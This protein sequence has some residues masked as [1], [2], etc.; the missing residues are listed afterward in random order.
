MKECTHVWK[1]KV[2]RKNNYIFAVCMRCNEPARTLVGT[3][4]GRHLCVIIGG[5]NEG[6]F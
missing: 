2:D 6:S 3:F 5:K 4:A 1:M